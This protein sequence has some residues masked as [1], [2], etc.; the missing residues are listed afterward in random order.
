MRDAF[1][2]VYA[3]V[4]FAET[5]SAVDGVAQEYVYA[6]VAFAPA[7]TLEGGGAHEYVYGNVAQGFVTGYANIRN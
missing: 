3:N 6:N 4:A 2:Y 1:E 5:D 7:S